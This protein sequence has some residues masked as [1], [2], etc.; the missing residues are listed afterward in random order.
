PAGGVGPY[1]YNWDGQTSSY[2]GTDQNPVDLAADTYDLT[3]TDDVACSRV[4]TAAV[5]ID[6]PPVIT[7]SEV[8]TNVDCFGDFTGEIDLTPGGG[9]PSGTGTGYTYAWTG[10]NGFNSTDEDITG[11][12]A[13][14]YNVTVTDGNGCLKDFGPYTVNQNLEINVTL[15][16]SSDISCTGEADGSATISVGGGTGP[17]AFSWDGQ[18]TAHNSTDQNPANLVADTYDLTVTDN[19]GCS[20][21]F[22][23]IV[24]ST[25]PPA[26]TASTN[27]TDVVCFG[28]FTGEIDLTP[29][30]GTPSGTGTGY[31]Y[32]WTGPNSFASTDED[33]T[34]LEAGDY[35]VT[36]TDGNGC[37]LDYGPNVVDNLNPEI[38][39][40]L[41]SSTD[42]SCNGLDDGAV[43]ISIDGG[44]APYSVSWNEPSLDYN[45]SQEDPDDLEAGTYDLTITDGIGCSRTFNDTVIIEEPLPLFA[46]FSITNANCFANS[47]GGIDITPSGGT[48]PYGFSW[49]G[50]DGFTSSDEDLSGI[51]PGDYTLVL[52][53]ANN[54]PTYSSTV[55][56]NSPPEIIVSSDVT[57]ISCNGENDGA[58]SITTTGGE[59]GYIYSWSGPG[60]FSSSEQNISSLI[61][62]DYNLSVTD[63]I[64]CT[65]DFTP[66][67][68]ITDPDPISYILTGKTDIT[69]FGENTGSIQI[70]V[71]GGT[72]LYSFS[73]KNSDGVEVSTDEDPSSL[74]ADTLSLTITDA[75]SC[76]S[77]YPDAVV[78]SSP[79]LLELLVTKTD[80]NCSGDGD[81][82][83]TLSASGGLPPYQFRLD[84]DPF[85]VDSQFT[86]LSG[87]DYSAET[88]DANGCIIAENV[89][90][91]E[92][93]P[94]DFNYQLDGAIS[95][96]GDSTATISFIEVSGGTTPYQ[97]SVD[98][99]TTFSNDPDFTN[100]PA[101]TYTL[102]LRDANLCER[103]IAPFTITEPDPLEIPSY[104]QTDVSTCFDSAE[105]SISISATGG[106]GSLNYSLDSNTPQSTGTFNSLL[107]GSH[108]VNITDANLCE[109][110]T[111]VE[112]DRP[113]ELLIS[114]A[115]LTNV[116][117][118]PGDSNGA[119]DVSATGGTG[120]ITYSL[121]GDPFQSSGSFTSLTAGNHTV[122][123]L[124]DNGCTNDS[125]L[126]L[127]EP[128]PITIDTETVVPVSCNGTATGEITII[129]SG[130]TAPYNFSLTPS[131]QSDNATGLFS[132][133]PAGDYT[134]S[135]TDAPG[136][137]PATSSIL[138]V[139]E[140]PA[141]SV[142]SVVINEIQ[143]N[144]SSNGK[145][146]IYIQGG[147]GPYDYSIDN[148]ATYIAD[149]A[150]TALGPGT[151]DLFV[152]DANGCVLPVDS[153]ALID[154]DLIPVTLDVTDADCFG[155][156]T[157]DVTANASGGWGKFEYSIDGT[158]FVSSGTFTNLAAGDYTLY[159]RDSL[160]C[161]VSNDFTV[162]QPDEI[163]AEITATD[164]EI[165]A[166]G[167]ITVSNVAGGTEPYQY[168]IDGF[169]GP[170][171]STITYTDLEAGTYLVVVRDDNGCTYSE[172]VEIQE[173]VPLYMEIDSSDV[174]CFGLDDGSIIFHPQNA[175]GTVQFSID[176]G[177]T[178]HSDS[179][180]NNLEGNT[181]YQLYAI[182]EDGK[183]FFGSVTIEEPGDIAFTKDIGSAD[184]NVFSP[185]GSVRL[186]I[187]GGT[188]NKRVTW[189]NDSVGSELN[190]LVSG[191]YYFEVKD[192]LNCTKSDSALIPA[193]V[194]VEAKAGNDTTV[195]EGESLILNGSAGDI[196]F[197]E[198]DSFIS[199]QSIPNPV[200]TNLTEPVSYIYT[201][202]ETASGLGCYDIDTMHIG[203]LP[204][205][206]LEIKQ[207]TIAFAGQ[208]I[209]LEI[210]S[211]GIFETYTWIPETGLDNSSI[212]DPV[213]TPDNSTTYSVQALNN[214][215]CIE[216]ASVTIE[217]VENLTVYNVFS[218]N[219]D[220]RNE[221]FEIEN[222]SSF[223]EID[224]RVFNRWG[225]LVFSSIGYAE[226][227]W[228][229]GTFNG[230]DV[231]LGTY[232]YVIIPYP[233]A[234]PIKGNVTIIR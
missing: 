154:P 78:I 103:S 106:T 67:A 122:A 177:A 71:T 181:T 194:T 200:V 99:G 40:T 54:C 109:K 61:A 69:C 115:N 81:G 70:D 108:V 46:I 171:S 11:L 31:T 166:L 119:I 197:W 49:T 110:D 141:L 51:G 138:T 92:P 17:Y 73:W 56:V 150:F 120:T 151:Y 33:I 47:D 196:V 114:S 201:V 94:L 77:N 19:L 127:S 220:S 5:T 102:L 13:G 152:R 88:K 37:S 1:T 6:E 128:L 124:D 74:A 29:G 53:D 7:A 21:V 30:G 178:T 145:I 176:G 213:A 62:G 36:I 167:T 186:T 158:N 57:N 226:D 164:Y 8:I 203:I 214:Y 59:P 217:I 100:I 90:I 204:V 187:T 75:N 83:I 174:T 117:G 182:D 35:N 2:N 179:V 111:I 34:G 160:L 135:V 219:G 208:S 155:D 97:Y 148:Q 156:A 16:A 185:T 76:S 55:T 184:C 149:S 205:Y 233:G 125:V 232:Y 15:D 38:N 136:C 168:S 112:L 225:S 129:A 222:A 107:G 50:P 169:D 26:I 224:I 193:N 123:M 143:C 72:P 20:R 191:W 146:T 216:T 230:K 189:S 87:G 27:I 84:S 41:L 113:D 52:S 43:N 162:A 48:M 45:N 4:F 221:Y 24:T 10:P 18:V 229:D 39:F 116:T 104:S 14:D 68:T 170:F 188:G 66:L 212:P 211:D 210:I 133:L 96:H 175:V 195:C 12:E 64:G 101:G 126:T 121:D 82:T 227:Q 172:T 22:S 32:A 93:D 23:D 118:C 231:P 132:N 60:G 9:T 206:G 165:D 95:C 207:D 209:Q 215:G 98:N 157:G 173:Y 198:P 163:T 218:P 89:T 228:W 139:P 105:G 142:D 131:I 28:E 65:Q 234:E 130:G 159:T 42:A 134:V 161:A 3:I 180:F 199:N 80:I 63:D 86:G 147:T 144:G 140:P 25:E 202:T 44:V 190:N 79:D 85:D 183:E 153:Y 223:P 91:I 137:N 192:S 58:I